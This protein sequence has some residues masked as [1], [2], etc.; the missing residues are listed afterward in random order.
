MQRVVRGAES[1]RVD[2]ETREQAFDDLVAWIERGVRPDGE[3]VLATDLS[4]IGLKWTPSCYLGG[5][6]RHASM[7]GPSVR[8][9]RF[10]SAVR[11]PGP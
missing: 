11:P 8:N 9:Q 3:D 5:S 6:A 4:R 1:L 7:T 10:R 2:G